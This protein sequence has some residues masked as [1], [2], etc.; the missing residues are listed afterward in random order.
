LHGDLHPG[1]MMQVDD[2]IY[3]FDFEDTLHSYLPLVYELALVM[4][5]LIF[6]RHESADEIMKLGQDFIKSYRSNG[7]LYQFHEKDVYAQSTLALRSLCVLT[8][9]EIEGNPIHAEEWNKFRNL[10]DL[11]A[12]TQPIL[13][14][15]L[16][17]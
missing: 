1:N 12:S 3:F 8:L 6:V 15:I 9:C 17:A 16:Q 2:T 10:S 5:R 11:A 14:A 7:G 4:E 13:R